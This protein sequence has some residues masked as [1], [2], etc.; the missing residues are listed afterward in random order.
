MQ[1]CT[2][3]GVD[4]S[5]FLAWRQ[6]LHT[7]F[8]GIWR[9]LTALPGRPPNGLQPTPSGGL[10]LGRSIRVEVELHLG[11]VDDPGQVITTVLLL[12]Y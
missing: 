12:A 7:A 9:T 11:L 1:Q 8:L 4:R 3:T 5:L 2:P 6:L 10:F